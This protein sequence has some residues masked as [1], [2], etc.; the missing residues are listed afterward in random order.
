MLFRKITQ[1]LVFNV[2]EI[3]KEIDVFVAFET[4]NNRGKLL[5]AL[6]LLKNR[7]IYLASH[8]PETDNGDG[9]RLRRV[10]NEAWKT[11][12]HNLGKN[13]NRPLADD[14]FLGTHLAFFYHDKLSPDIPTDD[15]QSQRF[16]ARSTVTLER[17]N[18]FLLGRLFTR[19]RLIGDTEDDLSKIDTGFLLGY[20]ASLR[21]TV[22]V[23]F[24]LSTPSA[25]NYSEPEK[26]LIE[27][28]GRLRGYGANPLMLSV[29]LKEKSPKKRATLLDAYERY[30]FCAS[31]KLGHRFSYSQRFLQWDAIRYMKGKLS[32][33][34]LITLFNNNVDQ[35][36]KEDSLADSLHDWMKNGP[37]YYGW[38]VINYFLYEYE[39]SLAEKSKTSRVRIDW[40]EF[41]KENYENDYSSIEHIYPQKARSSYWSD[42]FGGYTLTQKRMLRNSLGNL[43]AL[44]K[45]KNSSLSNKPFPD[46][47]GRE[48]DTVGYKYGSYSEIDVSI[49]DEWGSQQI[50]NRGLGMLRF[51]EKRWRL[52]VGD[53]NQQI[54]ALG[55]QFLQKK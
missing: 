43:L 33:E 2:Y 31:M 15:D 30:L 1:Q 37:G 22:Q 40:E 16:F 17:P 19:K 11:V 26:I 21:E 10:I 54:K 6:E 9:K 29:Y 53:R 28:I 5:S 38:R 39:I 23:Y 24:N 48:G 7:L 49:Q 52:A 25:S 44:S 4:M 36:F 32:I 41:C 55:L 47:I 18:N 46:K 45:P 3:S 51:L 8:I 27:R 50:L 42:R 35:F 12:Y 13:E 14:D 34:E 20:A